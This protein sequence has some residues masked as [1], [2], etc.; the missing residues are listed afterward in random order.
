MAK[1]TL[2]TNFLDDIMSASMNGKRQYEMINNPN[3]TVSFVDVTEYDQVGSTFG[4]GQ[5]NQTNTAVNGL[6][7]DLGGCSF[8]QEGED[9][10]IVGA[11]AVRKKLGSQVVLLGIVTS[12][13]TFDLSGYAGYK[14]FELDKNILGY[15]SGS[16][17]QSTGE[18]T[19]DET[20]VSGEVTISGHGYIM[21]G[22]IM[23]TG[24]GQMTGTATLAYPK[25][26]YLVY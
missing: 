15:V 6:G 2:P 9:F 24:N 11:D 13:E 26:V 23:R 16:Y 19:V 17:D 3:G 4:G 20:E 21:D 25:S 5:I 22:D 12:A 7:D 1:M 8:E 18:L 10:F 14:N